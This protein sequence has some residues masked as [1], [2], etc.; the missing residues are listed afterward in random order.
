MWSSPWRWRGGEAVAEN[1]LGKNIDGGTDR[2]LVEAGGDQRR[3]GLRQ[4]RRPRG[5]VGVGGEQ[6]RQPGASQG[7]SPPPG[8]A[9]VAA[10][11]RRRVELEDGA[12]RHLAAD[13]S[14]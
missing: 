6:K 14:V 11:E 3:R 2:A 8:L 10:G 1:R 13:H 7:D 5:R 4:L 12:A 9:A